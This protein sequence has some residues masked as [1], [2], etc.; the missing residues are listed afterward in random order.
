MSPSI[1]VILSAVS[2]IFL[3]PLAYLS[4]MTGFCMREPGLVRALTL[5]LLDGYSM[6]SELHIEVIPPLLVIVAV[7]HSI[8]VLETLDLKIRSS[9]RYL[10]AYIIFKIISW[11]LLGQVLAATI[12][13]VIG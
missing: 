8:T 13:Y 11:L 3:L 2:G 5:G 10:R 12:V 9:R 6:C 7:I 4:A 1:N